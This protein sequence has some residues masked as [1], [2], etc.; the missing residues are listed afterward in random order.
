MVREDQEAMALAAED[1]EKDEGKSQDVEEVGDGKGVD[2]EAGG[3]G[4]PEMEEGLEPGVEGEQPAREPKTYTV[5]VDNLE[6]VG[7]AI[8]Y[9]MITCN[10]LR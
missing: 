4:A 10:E 8:V 1:P 7:I 6:K 9:N 5:T 3:A 2:G